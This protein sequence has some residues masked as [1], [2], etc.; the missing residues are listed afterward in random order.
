[1]AVETIDTVPVD[2]RRRAARTTAALFLAGGLLMA[3]GGGLHPT[4]TG[5]TVDAHLL[6]MFDA[7]L[8][9]LSHWVLLA[10]AVAGFL[11]FVWAW[12]TH[13]FGPRV[14]RWLPVVAA[15]WAVGAA[16][17]VPH[18]LAAND[19]HALAHHEST[20]MLDTHLS[21]AVIAGPAV[22]A[23]VA[24]IVARAARSRVA[25]VLAAV[26]VVGGLLYAAASPL[27]VLTDDPAYS[28]LFAAQ[29][30]L[31][32]WLLGTGVRLLRT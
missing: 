25:W 13:A 14:Q 6:S 23:L 27:I 17:L 21:L 28:V 9:P 15:A 19:A 20:P 22:G 29:T 12:R 10:G 16:E 2:E 30:G 24:I 18:L 1:M 3:A 4:G 31:A 8:W 32:V 11:A 7:A 26:A 5:D